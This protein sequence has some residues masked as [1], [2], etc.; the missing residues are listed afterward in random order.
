[1]KSADSPS[2]AHELPEVDAALDALRDDFGELSDAISRT[3]ADVLVAVRAD[4][5]A[6]EQRIAALEAGGP[7]EPPPVEPP[8]VEPPPSG[9]SFLGRPAAAPIVRDGGSSVLIENVSIRGGS[10][11]SPSGIGITIRNVDGVIRLVDIDLADL[12]GGIYLYN[13]RGTLLIDGIRSRNIGNGTIGAGK[14][15]HI[16]LAECSLAGAIRRNRFLGGRT[17]DMLS[18]WHSGGRGAGQELVIEDNALQ[19]L[20]ADTATARAWDSS[21]GTGIIVGDGGGSAKNGWIIVRRNTLLTPGQVG[22]QI[23]DGPGL[24]IYDNVIVAERRRQNN[25][26][27]TTWE[28]NPKGVVRD[29]RYL[30]T[31]EDGSTPAPWSHNGWSGIDFR[32]N[33]EDAS[34]DPAALRVVL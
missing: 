11:A 19:G 25:N 34:L 29:N 13:C 6:L 16:Q 1:M 4:M 7:V 27:M 26:P 2:H 32:G 17:E 20:V 14:S 9:I 22:L 30:W 8:P 24:Q 33:V 15:N 23:I 3:A 28:G 12:V 31:K 5:I 18:T 10:L 21:S